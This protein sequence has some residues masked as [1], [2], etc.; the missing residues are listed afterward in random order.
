[1]FIYKIHIKGKDIVD[2]KSEHR[3]FKYLINREG[4]KTYFI[5][6]P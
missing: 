4:G 6:T 1:M 3:Y 2:D 5:S